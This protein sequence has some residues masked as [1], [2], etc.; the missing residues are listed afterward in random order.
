MIEPVKRTSKKGD[1]A[2]PLPKTYTGL[3][4]AFAP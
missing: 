3:M 4:Q 1:L 2:Q